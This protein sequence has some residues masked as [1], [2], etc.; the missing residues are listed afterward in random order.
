MLLLWSSG[1]YFSHI[2]Q[3]SSLYH[4]FLE[5]HS[6]IITLSELSMGIRTGGINHV[7]KAQ[8]QG[9]KDQTNYTRNHVA[10]RTVLRGSQAGR[11]GVSNG[12]NR[13]QPS[14]IF[15]LSLKQQEETNSKCQ[16]IFPSL[17]K[18]KRTFLLKFC[19]AMRTP[20]ST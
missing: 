2:C 19:V 10:G 8:P 1:L 14:G 15:S 12:G 5:K 18:I 9:T 17:Y 11:P 6:Y 16:T 7:T 3:Y 4:S 20:G 13:L